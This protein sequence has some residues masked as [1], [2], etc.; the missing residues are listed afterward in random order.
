MSCQRCNSDR[1][2]EI[3]SKSS[4]CNFVDFQGAEYNG[5]VPNDLGI[6]GGDYIRFKYCLDCGQIQG[7]FPLPETCLEVSEEDQ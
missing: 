6:G 3:N 5:Y 1:I 7:N 4:D 2:V